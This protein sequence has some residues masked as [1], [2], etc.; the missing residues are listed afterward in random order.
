MIK[1]KAKDVFRNWSFYLFSFSFILFIL[2]FFIVALYD[3][4]VVLSN[5]IYYALSFIMAVSY[6]VG[7]VLFL[8]YAGLKIYEKLRK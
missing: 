5:W 8:L 3:A 6:F 4:R 1:I 2:V 7:G